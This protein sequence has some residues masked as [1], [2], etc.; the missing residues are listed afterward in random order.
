MELWWGICDAFGGTSPITTYGVHG[1]DALLAPVVTCTARCVP[2]ETLSLLMH[3]FICLSRTTR[4]FTDLFFDFLPIST[5]SVQNLA[6][7]LYQC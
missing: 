1:P 6:L 4:S 3:V 5:P 2:E 7:L